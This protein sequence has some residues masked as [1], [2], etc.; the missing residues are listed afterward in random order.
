MEVFSHKNSLQVRKNQKIKNNNK[1][2]KKGKLKRKK[3]N[4]SKKSPSNRRKNSTSMKKSQFK[5]FKN[6]STSSQPYSTYKPSTGQIVT[7]WQCKTIRIP[8]MPTLH[9]SK[10]TSKITW[11]NCVRKHSDNSS[12]HQ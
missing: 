12:Y 2:R 1:K 3:S 9:P 5:P 10:S 4:R 8:K 6:S 11:K 7:S